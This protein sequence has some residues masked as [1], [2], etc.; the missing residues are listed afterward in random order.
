MLIVII[1]SLLLGTFTVAMLATVI[2]SCIRI[3]RNP[4][5]RMGNGGPRF[6]EV[7]KVKTQTIFKE[8]V[9]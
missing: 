9:R 5:L 2:I 3:T 1:S 7:E 6:I 4:T 8:K